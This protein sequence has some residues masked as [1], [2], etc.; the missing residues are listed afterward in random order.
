M[1]AL[2]T[3]K[4]TQVNT[5]RTKFHVKTVSTMRILKIALERPAYLGNLSCSFCAL[6]SVL[7]Y[8]VNSTI[9]GRLK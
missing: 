3:A 8:G 5:M 2:K 7:A 4:I 6:N 1:F 9:A